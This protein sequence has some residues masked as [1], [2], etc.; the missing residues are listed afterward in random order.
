[1]PEEANEVARFSLQRSGSEAFLRDYGIKGWPSL[2]REEDLRW[3]RE[4][5]TGDMSEM[6]K[7]TQSGR[8]W[9]E[10]DHHGG[11]LSIFSFWVTEAQVADST[12]PRL[13]ERVH[14]DGGTP[15]AVEYRDSGHP[16]LFSPRARKT[17]KLASKVAPE[18]LPR[19]IIDILVKGHS[20]AILDDTNHMSPR[21]RNRQTTP[22]SDRSAKRGR[23]PES[24]SQGEQT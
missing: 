15:I 17:S 4:R 10:A 5:H 1:M 20:K 13:C 21:Q 7:R 8:V 12:L 9:A 3:L 22:G 16:M 2:L 6:R 23:L 24:H 11:M 14:L 19:E 18:L